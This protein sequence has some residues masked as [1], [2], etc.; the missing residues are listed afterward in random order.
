MP[1]VRWP[2]KP[3]TTS[4]ASFSTSRRAI[5]RRRSGSSNRST[6][7]PPVCKPFPN[8]AALAAGP[9]PANSWCGAVALHL[10]L[11]NQ[12]QTVE[13]ARVWHPAR[14]GRKAA[15]RSVPLRANTATARIG[16]KFLAAGRR[17]ATVH[18]CHTP[19][20]GPRWRR[21]IAFLVPLDRLI[22]N[23]QSGHTS[24]TRRDERLRSQIPQPD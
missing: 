15:H 10:G 23:L 13:I 5:L 8:A 1:A 12:R 24:S 17:L 18:R 16:R 4:N 7:P 6:R 3:L 9:V 19:S 21:P 20:G 11:S 2:P 14:T 22:A